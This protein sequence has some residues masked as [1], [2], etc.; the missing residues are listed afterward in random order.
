LKKHFVYKFINYYDEIIYIGKTSNIKNRIKTHFGKNGHLDFVCYN[1]TKKIM[2]S[3]VN[4]AYNAEIIETYLIHKYKPL[5][6]DE[7]KYKGNSKDIFVNIEEPIWKNLLFNKIKQNGEYFLVEYINN[8]I[9]WLNKSIHLK[10]SKLAFEFNLNKIHSYWIEWEL[11][12]SN[13][14]KTFTKEDFLI[15]MNYIKNNINCYLSD[16]DE[17]LNVTTNEQLSNN[18]IAVNINIKNNSELNIINKSLQMEILE[19]Y[20][21][22]TFKLPIF[23]IDFI[24]KLEEKIL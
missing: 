4:S 11:F 23:T 16:F 8:E 13:F 7:K 9:P 21:E 19:K 12:A 20:D 5:Y 17:C 22:H 2:Y 1:N 15:L 6:N 3:E 10:P 18:F 14:M 24:R